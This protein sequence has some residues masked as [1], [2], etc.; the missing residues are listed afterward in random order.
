MVIIAYHG[1]VTSSAASSSLPCISANVPKLA[2]ESLIVH[3]VCYWETTLTLS[4][5]EQKSRRKCGFPLQYFLRCL[6]R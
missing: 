6:A 4:I 3:A 5:K 2:K 1:A